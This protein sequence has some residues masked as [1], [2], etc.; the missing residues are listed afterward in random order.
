M[1]PKSP[2]L[3]DVA[4]EVGL[5][6]SAV[7]AALSGNRSTISLPEETRLKILSVAKKLNYRPSI[8]ARSMSEQRSFLVGLLL[9]DVNTSLATEL[10]RGIQGEVVGHDC[11]PV[12]FSHA[13]PEQERA[14]LKSCLDRKV[15]ALIVNTSMCGALADPSRKSRRVLSSHTPVVEVFGRGHQPWVV[16]DFRA[17]GRIATEHLL[18]LG[19]HRIA[20]LTHEH[21]L[22][23]DDTRGAADQT[24]AGEHWNARE[25]F[26][27]YEAAMREAGRSPVVLTHPLQDAARPELA[28]TDQV[29]ALA[30]QMLAG[31]DRPT[32]VICYDD[33]QAYGL[34]RGAKAMGLVVPRDLSVVGHLD[35]EASS[36]IDPA[37]TTLKVPASQVG[38]KAAQM[39]FDMMQNQ[40]VSNTSFVPELV[41]RG[42]TAEVPN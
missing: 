41:V 36:L 26:E 31:D 28:W 23:A 25:H 8:L 33:R 7:S 19:H 35:R 10:I 27:G 17:S 5:S 21:Y 30:P 9:W 24:G 13:N 15:D 4:R 18:A 2:T 16:L 39:C 11:A 22:G 3:K 37:L 40:P 32:A 29:A 12:V 38:A 6:K 1:A 42:S 34:F 14:N 20:L